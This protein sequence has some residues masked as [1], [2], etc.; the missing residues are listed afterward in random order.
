MP[1]FDYI[2]DVL[3]SKHTMSSPCS[4]YAKSAVYPVNRSNMDLDIY[5]VYN[6]VNPR[7]RES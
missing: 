1:L 2:A 6:H 3:T 7:F 4:E 5:G